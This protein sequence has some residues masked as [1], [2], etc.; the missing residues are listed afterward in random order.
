MLPT[1]LYAIGFALQVVGGL[2]VLAEIRDDRRAAKK[3]HSG[4]PTWDDIGA[5][6]E[7]VRSGLSA[8]GGRLLGVALIFVGAAVA[9]TANLT[10]L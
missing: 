4:G 8:V 2:I 1:V 10:A 9:L 5:A 7:V 6:P 3:I